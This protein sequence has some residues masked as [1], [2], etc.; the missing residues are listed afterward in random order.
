MAKSRV[1]IRKSASSGLLL[2]TLRE[3]DKIRRRNHG[4]SYDCMHAAASVSR[5]FGRFVSYVQFETPK[6]PAYLIALDFPEEGLKNVHSGLTGIATK[7]LGKRFARVMPQ[8]LEEMGN[9]DGAIVVN[10]AGKV[11]RVGAQLTNLDTRRVLHERRKELGK[12]YSPPA[13]LGFSGEVGT[14]HTSALAAAYKHPGTKIVTLSEESG[15]IRV[16][17]NGKIIASTNKKDRVHG[18]MRIVRRD[19]ENAFEKIAALAMA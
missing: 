12:H 16:Y 4:L 2:R 15:D 7:Y 3:V 14:R 11:V 19:S 10:N 1:N 13:L 9:C 8:L 6:K 5:V 18:R 17:E